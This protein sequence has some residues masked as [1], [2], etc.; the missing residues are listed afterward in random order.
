MIKLQLQLEDHEYAQ[1]Q[2]RADRSGVSEVDVAKKLLLQATRYL[3]TNQPVIV[4][5]GPLL[6]Q[7]TA[8]LGGLPLRHAQDL[9]ERVDQL[10]GISFGHLRLPFSPNHL[11]ALQEK[12]DRQGKT[13]EQLLEEA[14]PRVYE[15]F[16]DLFSRA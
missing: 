7:V 9:A 5:A 11:Q 2:E 6:E 16:F 13:V 15:Q 10:A 14:A 8:T 12:A 4:L 1:V 3:P